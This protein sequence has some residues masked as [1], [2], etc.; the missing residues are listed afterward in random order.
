VR[1]FENCTEISSDRAF[2]ARF[3]EGSDQERSNPEGLDPSKSDREKSNLKG[4]PG[5]GGI[6]KGWTGIYSYRYS[7]LTSIVFLIL[8]IEHIE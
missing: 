8:T 2:S 6:G 7:L 3:P 5:K 1:T 4:R